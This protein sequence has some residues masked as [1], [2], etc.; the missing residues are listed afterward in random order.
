MLTK[1]AFYALLE[2]SLYNTT[3]KVLGSLT[4]SA[5]HYKEMFESLDLPIATILLEAAIEYDYFYPDWVGIF[6][7]ILEKRRG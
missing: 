4:V 5:V 1:I 2:N 7:E 6:T 3:G